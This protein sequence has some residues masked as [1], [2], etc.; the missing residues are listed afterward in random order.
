MKKAFQ[1]MA[2][3]FAV[4]FVL[5]VPVLSAA[6]GIRNV[7]K[8]SKENQPYQVRDNTG[9]PSFDDIRAVGDADTISAPATTDYLSAYEYKYI[10]A[11]KGLSV[12]VYR[13]PKS[14][15]NTYNTTAMGYCGTKVK[16]LAVDSEEDLACAL[17]KTEKNETRAGWIPL[18]YLSD[19]YPGE[20]YNF[21]HFADQYSYVEYEDADVKWSKTNFVNS[22]T[23]YTEFTDIQNDV[24]ALTIDYQV[25]SRNGVSDPSGAR[26]VYFNDGSG[27]EIA[28]S[29][30]VNQELSPVHYTI[31]FDSPTDVAGVAVIP[32]N[33]RTEGFLFRTFVV[34][35]DVAA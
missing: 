29:F 23:K 10:K 26:D 27:W 15:R 14:A 32:Q 28:G 5:S 35:I 17:Y 11:P 21:G 25:I 1:L 3:V 18:E 8:G 7:I 20:S 2:M 31:N 4:I 6:D 24:L 33:L 22:G 12:Y 13:S 9:G 30:T 19:F 34:D 16:I